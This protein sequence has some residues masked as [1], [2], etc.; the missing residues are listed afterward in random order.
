[1]PACLMGQVALV[2][3]VW[4][5]H[6]SGKASSYS[7]VSE[8]HML[9]FSFRENHCVHQQ[10]HVEESQV[11]SGASTKYRASNPSNAVLLQS[12]SRQEQDI[13]AEC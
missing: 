7:Q 8:Q 4:A 3:V 9:P 6:T 13:K 10:Q 12:S 5:A 11:W 1:M 2:P